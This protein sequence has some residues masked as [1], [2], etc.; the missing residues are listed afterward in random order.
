M[1]SI[2]LDINK[3]SQEAILKG[4]KYRKKEMKIYLWLL[5]FSLI[6]FITILYVIKD[7]FFIILGLLSLLILYLIVNLYSNYCLIKF[8]Q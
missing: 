8:V 5:V 2:I 7:F 4:E 3:Y 1:S 6:D